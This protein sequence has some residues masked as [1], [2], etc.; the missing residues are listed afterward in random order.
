MKGAILAVSGQRSR[1]LTCLSHSDQ[2][3]H[4]S[5]IG[6]NDRRRPC[7]GRPAHLGR[8]ARHESGIGQ[9]WGRISCT[10][11]GASAARS[12]PPHSPRLRPRRS[13]RAPAARPGC[14]ARPRFLRRRGCAGPT[15]APRRQ[16]CPDASHPAGWTRRCA[17]SR[18]CRC[19]RG[20]ARLPGLRHLPQGADLQQSIDQEYQGQAWAAAPCSRPRPRPRIMSGPPRR[21]TTSPSGSGS[22]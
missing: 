17:A 4:G 10:E 5:E 1:L 7:I 15:R 2:R 18:S 14:P 9:G 21:N 6:N 22:G 11:I 3:R 13:R 16:S 19:R 8:S 20:R 12:S